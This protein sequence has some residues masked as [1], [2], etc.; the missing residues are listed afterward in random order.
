MLLKE[1][2]TTGI[3]VCPATPAQT[4][5]ASL[6][7]K[8]DISEDASFEHTSLSL[9]FR[10]GFTVS[11]DFISSKASPGQMAKFDLYDEGCTK[12]TGSTKEILANATS[13]GIKTIVPDNTALAAASP[14][15]SA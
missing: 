14:E 2:P 7:Q 9:S 5:P 6:K 15:T 12:D 8:V 11:E 10:L 4:G 13:T 1:I 3:C